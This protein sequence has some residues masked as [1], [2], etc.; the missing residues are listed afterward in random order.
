MVEV[1]F[2]VFERVEMSAS[3][4]LKRVEVGFRMFKRVEVGFRMPGVE[5][6]FRVLGKLKGC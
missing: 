3:R 4:V 6:C 1:A 5:V 2:S